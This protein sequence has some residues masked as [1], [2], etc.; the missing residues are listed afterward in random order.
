MKNYFEKMNLPEYTYLIY[1]ENAKSV[2]I[3]K[4]R[5]ELIRRLRWEMKK[6]Q[7]LM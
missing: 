5:E 4:T 6:I 2:I 7:H 1:L 3:P